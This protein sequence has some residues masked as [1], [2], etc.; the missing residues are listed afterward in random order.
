[1]ITPQASAMSFIQYD[2][3]LDS[4]TLVERLLKDQSML[5]IP[6]ACFGVENHIRFSSALPDEYL[7][8]G[9]GRFNQLVE[10]V[11]G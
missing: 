10:A 7:R 3:P 4:L 8:T 1:M 11:R 2:L 6:G 5:V 9:L